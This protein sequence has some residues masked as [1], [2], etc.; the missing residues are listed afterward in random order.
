M[1]RLVGLKDKKKYSYDD[2]L[3]FFRK[4]SFDELVKISEEGKAY[5][6]VDGY[7]ALMRWRAVIVNPASMDK[8]Y[9]GKLEKKVDEDIMQIAIGDDDEAFYEALIKK[10]TAQL[11]SGGISQQEV[12]RLSQNINIF[13]K[14]LREI[15]SR[16]PKSGTVLER[17]L[18][19]ADKQDT[20][21]S[22]KIDAKES[23]PVKTTSPAAVGA[24][25]NKKTIVRAS[26]TQK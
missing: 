23:T 2:W 11:N 1:K 14:E 17:V 4:K 7:S 3:E 16:R 13:R 26:K 25:K 18:A 10:N 20:K 21:S 5:L 24:K 12:A 9:K 15:R 6:P 22:P 19:A 8:L